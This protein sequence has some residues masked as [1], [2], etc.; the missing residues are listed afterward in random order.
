MTKEQTEQLLTGLVGIGAAILAGAAPR[1]AADFA[2]GAIIREAPHLFKIAA[3]VLARGELTPAQRA[4]AQREAEAL[5]QG[6]VAI[7]AATTPT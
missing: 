1:A 3:I 7:P 4:E 5:S 2:L 6:L